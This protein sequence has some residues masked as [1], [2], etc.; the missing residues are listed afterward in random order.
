MRKIYGARY[1]T[2]NDPLAF[3]KTKLKEAGFAPLPDWRDALARYIKEE[4]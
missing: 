2:K 1:S 3:N 4:L